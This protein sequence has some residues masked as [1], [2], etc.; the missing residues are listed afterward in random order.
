[1]DQLIAKKSIIQCIFKYNTMVYMSFPEEHWQHFV[2]HL[3]SQCAKIYEENYSSERFLVAALIYADKYIS[4]NYH[5][6]EEISFVSILIASLLVSFK[7]W[8]DH[9][10]IV[11]NE[12]FAN[13]SG[14]HHISLKEI[15]NMEI[16]ILEGIDYSLMVTESQMNNFVQESVASSINPFLEGILGDEQQ[17]LVSLYSETHIM[18]N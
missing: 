6:H 15:N 4:N 10:N 12:A 17:R 1:M 18:S 13:L 11:A 8:G 9:T 7:F 3:V 2:D 5:Q 14:I 16:K